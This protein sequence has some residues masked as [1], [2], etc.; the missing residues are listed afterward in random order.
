MCFELL[1]HKKPQW[2][3]PKVHLH[4]SPTELMR[5]DYVEAQLQGAQSSALSVYTDNMF[6]KRCPSFPVCI[7]R[8]SK[9]AGRSRSASREGKVRRRH[10]LTDLGTRHRQ[11]HPGWR[12]FPQSVRCRHRPRSGPA[13]P[14]GPPEKTGWRKKRKTKQKTE[15]K[16]QF[17]N[18]SWQYRPSSAHSWTGNTWAESQ[19]P[20]PLSP[21]DKMSPLDL[22]SVT[23]SNNLRRLLLGR[24][25]HAG[26]N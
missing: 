10:E 5:R 3:S 7:D 20:R 8:P 2:T 17:K 4:P 9:Q 26:S 1:F 14:P 23:V 11:G 19:A 24:R 21:S 12:C 16:T 6:S 15:L 22:G 25:T 18:Q 13:A